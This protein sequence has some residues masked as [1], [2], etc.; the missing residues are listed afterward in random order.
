M[1]VFVV[2]NKERGVVEFDR[3][4]ATEHGARAYC[5]QQNAKP[6]YYGRCTFSETEVRETPV[7]AF[8]T[9]VES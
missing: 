9:G 1:K 8:E 6:I 2:F 7:L 5:Q 3:I 4:Y